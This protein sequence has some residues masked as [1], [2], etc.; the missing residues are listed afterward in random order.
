MDLMTHE[1]V[2]GSL[3]LRFCL[4]KI[5]KKRAADGP[6]N[7]LEHELQIEDRQFHFKQVFQMIFLVRFSNYIN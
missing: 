3:V 6:Y 5:F 2:D 7:N 1:E 4:R